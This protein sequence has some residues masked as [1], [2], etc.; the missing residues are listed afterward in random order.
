MFTCGASSYCGRLCRSAVTSDGFPQVQQTVH[1]INDLE[2]RKVSSINRY[3]QH[4]TGRLHSRCYSATWPRNPLTRHKSQKSQSC[5]KRRESRDSPYQ[6]REVTQPL[7]QS[8]N[9][10]TE[11]KIEKGNSVQEDWKDRG[12]PECCLSC[13][14]KHHHSQREKTQSFET[15]P[16]LLGAGREGIYIQISMWGNNVNIWI[17]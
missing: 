10:K 3:C 17:L 16:I 7:W 2:E 9:D 4:E 14:R 12:G 6:Q 15:E 8:S 5:D 13:L 11:V 1:P